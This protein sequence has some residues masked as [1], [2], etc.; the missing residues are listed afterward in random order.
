MRLGV[1]AEDAVDHAAVRVED[2]VHRAVEAAHRRDLVDV[3]AHRAG[4]GAVV[5]LR[6]GD[7]G[8]VVRLDRRVRDDARQDQLAAAAGAP[9]VRLRLADRD[10]QVAR[11]DLVV[12]PDGRAAG[13]D[14][15]ERVGVGVLRVV[16]M[17]RP[18]VRLHPRQVVAPDLLLH[19]R[20]GH[21]EHLPVRADDPDVANT[22]RLDD[23]EN[24]RQELRGRG[25]AE[26]VVDD[27]GDAVLPGEELGEGR[28]VEGLRE[29]LRAPPRWYRRPAPARRG[30]SPQPGSR[31]GSRASS[32]SRC[33]LDSSSVAPIASG[34]IDSYGITAL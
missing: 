4:I 19:V 34:S 32:V 2:H 15:D 17:E 8:A 28:P 14:A 23:V 20:L 1:R 22:C 12:Q 29:R 18:A 24:G 16:L 13:R 10:L 25:R 9:V 21:R 33:F 31:S 7:E 11:R 5:R 3:G 26:L 30:R 6:R 27:H